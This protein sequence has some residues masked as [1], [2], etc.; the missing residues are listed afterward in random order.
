MSAARIV[1]AGAHSGAVAYEK[2][3]RKAIACNPR[4]AATSIFTFSLARTSP[5]DSFAIAP[6]G[7]LEI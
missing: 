2:I 3:R 4:S 7:G 1:V 6:G 5:K